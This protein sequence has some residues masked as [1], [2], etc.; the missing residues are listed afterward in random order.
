MQSNIGLIRLISR[1]AE[2]GWTV[3][4]MYSMLSLV[5]PDEVAWAI[6][7]ASNLQRATSQTNVED[8]KQ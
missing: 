2:K 5:D 6:V 4:Q 7:A 3:E 8:P 1:L